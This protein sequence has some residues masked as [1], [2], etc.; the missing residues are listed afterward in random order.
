MSKLYSGQKIINGLQRAG[1]YVIPIK[2]SHVKMRGICFGKLQTVIVPKH[3]EVAMGTP[4]R[5]LRQASMSYEE[6]KSFI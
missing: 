3:R 2:G 5:I 6:L 1:F 4:Q